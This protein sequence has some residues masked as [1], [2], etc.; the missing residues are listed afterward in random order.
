MNVSKSKTYLHQ[1]TGKYS[2]I[3]L[4]LCFPALLPNFTWK[5]TDDLCGS[6]HFPIIFSSTQPSSTERPRKWKLSKANWNKFDT[7][8]QQ[9]ISRDKF[10]NCDDPI[11]LFTSLLLDA[12]KASVP[13]TS[14]NPKRPD[15]PW[16]NDE[17][18]QAVKDRKDALK[19]FNLRSSP[20][21]HNQFRIFRAKAQRTI[22]DSK[23]KS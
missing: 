21:N 3:D 22:K 19:R 20:E 13:Q 18:K 10:E 11:K 15:K 8:C 4:T 17:C 1:A 6:D 23:R 9:A 5:V 12:V 7:F 2:S 14:T 16:Y